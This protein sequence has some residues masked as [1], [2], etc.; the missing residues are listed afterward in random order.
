MDTAMVIAGATASGPTVA[1]SNNEALARTIPAIAWMFRIEEH[2]SWETLSEM[3]MKMRAEVP[4][5]K[6]RVRD[7]LGLAEGQVFATLSPDTEDVPIRIG[8]VQLGWS[9][10]EVVEQKMALRV[11]RLD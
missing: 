1:A 4:L 11:T 2:P 8:N 6:F 9:E 7:L 3:R 5:S 10:F